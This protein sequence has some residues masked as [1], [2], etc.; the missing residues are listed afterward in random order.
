MKIIPNTKIFI[1]DKVLICDNDGPFE[2]IGIILDGST[3][4]KLIVK[5]NDDE[6]M[7]F[8]LDK[9]SGAYVAQ[10]SDNHLFLYFIG[11]MPFQFDENGKVFSQA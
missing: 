3:K 8:E 9:K 7:M 5:D 4:K 1:G 2:T 10:I 6:H 11:K